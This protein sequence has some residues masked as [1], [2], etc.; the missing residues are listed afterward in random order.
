MKTFFFPSPTALKSLEAFSDYIIPKALSQIQSSSNL[1]FLI[2]LSCFHP[3]FS[4]AG[5][6]LLNPIWYP[7]LWASSSARQCCLFCVAAG[8]CPCCLYRQRRQ[9]FLNSAKTHACLVS[10]VHT[11]R[12]YIFLFILMKIFH[13]SFCIYNSEY[14]WYWSILPNWKLFR[15]FRNLENTDTRF[16]LGNEFFSIA[17]NSKFTQLHKIWWW[18]YIWGFFYKENRKKLV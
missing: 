9:V 11:L 17:N 8:I 1:L 10:T 4:R 15:K 16:F 14:F 18:C 5:R 12:T 3:F 6:I 2:M 13:L 7:C